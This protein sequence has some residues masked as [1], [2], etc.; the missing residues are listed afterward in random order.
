MKHYNGRYPTN[1]SGLIA[2]TGMV[3]GIATAIASVV[4]AYYL[5]DLFLQGPGQDIGVWQLYVFF[6]GIAIGLIKIW[7]F[8]LLSRYVKLREEQTKMLEIMVNVPP[9]L[10]GVDP[11]IK[12]LLSN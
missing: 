4:A 5:P 9:T 6:S 3:I 1:L 12:S 2:F 7:L 11:N 10:D 8:W